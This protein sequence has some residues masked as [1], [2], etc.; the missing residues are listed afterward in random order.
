MPGLLVSSFDA[1]IDL[2][3]TLLAAQP[4][5]ARR[6]CSRWT[7]RHTFSKVINI[8]ALYLG[9]VAGLWPLKTKGSQ[10]LD[11][12][13]PLIDHF[14]LRIPYSSLDL[15]EGTLSLSLSCVGVVCV[16]ETGFVFRFIR[17]FMFVF[18]CAFASECL[19]L[20]VRMCVCTCACVCV[21]QCVCVSLSVCVCICVCVCV[22]LCVCLY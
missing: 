12:R 10:G 21:C 17:V 18:V 14:D 2:G 15:S 22:S 1:G 8:V 5:P 9:I 4:P 13:L 11:K 3:G 19:S 6:G 16:Y 20:S 7:S